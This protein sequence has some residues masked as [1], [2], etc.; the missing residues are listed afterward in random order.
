MQHTVN[1]SELTAGKTNR[2]GKNQDVTGEADIE[3]TTGRE[4]FE[5]DDSLLHGSYGWYRNETDG[6]S[7]RIG[8]F[9]IEI[10]SKIIRY[11][12]ETL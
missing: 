10:H 6:T 11:N 5:F 8:S 12:P 7:R 4:P 9:D 2:N 1:G 3:N